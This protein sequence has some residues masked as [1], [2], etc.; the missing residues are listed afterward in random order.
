MHKILI[1]L[2]VDQPLHSE[3]ITSREQLAVLIEWAIALA[4]HGHFEL[5]KCDSVVA[6]P[7]S[8][9]QVDASIPQHTI[10]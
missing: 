1:D 10:Y 3:Q 9:N 7:L 5:V 6:I 8:E 4:L 2:K